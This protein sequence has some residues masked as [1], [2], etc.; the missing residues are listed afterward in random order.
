MSTDQSIKAT[1]VTIVADKVAVNTKEMDLSKIMDAAEAATLKTM[2][3]DKS[4]I[5]NGTLL[6]PLSLILSDNSQL[7]ELAI[8]AARAKAV[9]DTLGSSYGNLDARMRPVNATFA[10]QAATLSLFNN[11]H[12]DLIATLGIE[13]GMQA[14]R[15]KAWA[16][17]KKNIDEARAALNLYNK[18]A[19][20]GIYRLYYV[21]DALKMVGGSL[22]A[23]GSLLDSLGVKQGKVLGQ[24]GSGMT[25][26]STNIETML[27][28]GLSFVQYFSAATSMIQNAFS[29]YSGLFG[30]NGL[31]GSGQYDNEHAEGW[32]KSLGVVNPQ[33]LA[34]IQ[35]RITELRDAGMDKMDA[36]TVAEMESIAPIIAARGKI[37]QDQADKMSWKI[38]HGIE[39]LKGGHDAWHAAY[40]PIL[41]ILDQVDKKNIEFTDHM[42][43]LVSGLTRHGML[44][45]D[46]F[47]KVQ[48]V[49]SDD[50][51]RAWMSETARGVR[52]GSVSLGEFGRQLTLLASEGLRRGIDFTGQLE[53]MLLA[54]A[55]AGWKQVDV[56]EVINNLIKAQETV[57]NQKIKELQQANVNLKNVTQQIHDARWDLFKYEKFTLPEAKKNYRRQFEEG[58]WSYTRKNDIT[59]VDKAGRDR[60]V[61][62]S[63]KYS[64]AE[65]FKEINRTIHAYTEG[66]SKSLNFKQMQE[67]VESTDPKGQQAVAEYLELRNQGLQMADQIAALNLQREELQ[68]SRT[69]IKDQL[70]KEREKLT[71][72]TTV[73]NTIVTGWP[74]LEGNTSKTNE[75]LDKIYR[76]GIPTR[77]AIPEAMGGL[78]FNERLYR[79][80]EAGPEFI[81]SNAALRRY[82]LPLM[83]AINAGSWAPT[84]IPVPVTASAAPVAVD[85]R[86]SVDNRN[87]RILVTPSVDG[88]SGAAAAIDFDYLDGSL[89]PLLKEHRMLRGGAR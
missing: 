6:A 1:T 15:A 25:G 81:M 85:V 44:T 79:V 76:D 74:T 18:D 64:G 60:G 21:S 61:L 12:G 83:E 23:V 4:N 58:E 49:A 50:S 16:D 7:K 67:I 59:N 80:A 87:K 75:W 43:A 84:A 33:I 82:G 8:Y 55:S 19:K 5:L 77:A 65:A 38:S 63:G 46:V 11:T 37:N 35:K 54:A 34:Q 70:Q 40:Q 28:S 69:E 2:S 14:A 22:S 78:L 29:I 17:H 71:D 68:R 10:K 30:R 3:S 51:L 36:R 47:K 27:T 9:I 86:V 52:E 39:V 45:E 88:R 26:L 66:Y 72:L 62:E 57:V 20:E 32:L 48:K 24:V 42:S 53:D 13:K 31:F 56:L 41:A 89:M 73:K